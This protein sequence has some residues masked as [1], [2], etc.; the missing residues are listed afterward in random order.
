M[1]GPRNTSATIGFGKSFPPTALLCLAFAA[2]AGYEKDKQQPSR[3]LTEPVDS[4]FVEIGDNPEFEA[5]LRQMKVDADTISV[6]QANLL[7]YKFQTS[8]MKYLPDNLRF[9]YLGHMGTDGGRRGQRFND[10]EL[11]LF[12]D[13][14][15]YGALGVFDFRASTKPSKETLARC[16]VGNRD[17]FV[18]C[19]FVDHN[20]SVGANLPELGQRSVREVL[21]HLEDQT[22]E[23]EQRPRKTKPPAMQ[24]EDILSIRQVNLF[25]YK[26]VTTSMTKIPDELMV[27]YL[28]PLG[29][30]SGR[31]GPAAKPPQEA[32]FLSWQVHKDDTPVFTFRLSTQRNKD[33]LTQCRVDNRNLFVSATFIAGN[34]SVDD[35]LPELEGRSI[36]EVLKY[37]E[38]ERP[39]E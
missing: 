6:R 24:D 37:L 23:A 27:R 25:H 34:R 33:T 13:W 14:R 16:R 8:C 39:K 36:R 12:L 29:R 32:D 10:P 9:Q 2:I 4:P 38:I 19:T 22:N 21:K 17:L 5:K 3:G 15:I 11:T 18:S 28:G 30:H 20:R 7:H 26:F 35:K 31:L 1:A